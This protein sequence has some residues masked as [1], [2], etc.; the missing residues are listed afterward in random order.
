ML[1]QLAL[2]MTRRVNRAIEREIFTAVGYYVSAAAA[3]S[4]IARYH[5]NV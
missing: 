1:L 5:D 2:V 4:V 3:A